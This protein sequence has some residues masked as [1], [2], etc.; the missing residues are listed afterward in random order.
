M[1]REDRR[2]FRTKVQKVR[3]PTAYTVRS[4]ITT[5]MTRSGTMWIGIS[6]VGRRDPRRPR[7]HAFLVSAGCFAAPRWLAHPSSGKTPQP[8][9][10]LM[11]PPPNS[12][13]CQPPSPTRFSWRCHGL[14]RRQPPSAAEAGNHD[15]SSAAVWRSPRP[16]SS[17]YPCPRCLRDSHHDRHRRLVRRAGWL[18]AGS[19]HQRG[20]GGGGCA[21]TVPPRLDQPNGSVTTNLARP[22]PPP[23][24]PGHP[25][26]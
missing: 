6:P 4:R 13:R 5:A 25:I 15:S 2:R 7:R 14:S 23:W 10:S 24:L 17:A 1:D 26:E 11:T 18:A 19:A 12:R 3:D 20:G 9:Q 21:H 16:A 8:H 22:L